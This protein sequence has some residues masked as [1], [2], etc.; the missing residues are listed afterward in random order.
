MLIGWKNSHGACLERYCAQLN[1]I[2]V[3][4]QYGGAGNADRRPRNE[5]AD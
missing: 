2:P 3:W 5:S 1:K 4:Y